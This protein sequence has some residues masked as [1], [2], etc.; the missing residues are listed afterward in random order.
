MAG[1]RSTPVRWPTRSRNASPMRPPPQPMSR[2]EAKRRPGA[3]ALERFGDEGRGAVA[4][5]AGQMRFEARRVLIEEPRHIGRGKAAWRVAPPDERKSR[6]RP[7]RVGG[8][9]AERGAKGLGR[10]VDIAEPGAGFAESEP[11]RRP[12]RRALEGLL[13]D[14]GGRRRS[15]PRRPRPGRRRSG[16]RRA[17]RRRRAGRPFERALSASCAAGCRNRRR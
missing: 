12:V 4:E 15:R 7:L 13:E 16:A 2:A 3:A 6:R 5:R 14:I 9:G 1:E 10:G 11:R 8:V 17:D